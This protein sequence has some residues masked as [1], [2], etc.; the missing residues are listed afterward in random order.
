MT[1]QEVTQEQYEQLIDDAAYLQD[2]AEALSYVIDSVPYGDNPP[3]G[4]SIYSMLQLIDHAQVSYY[5]PVIEKVFSEV[6]EIKLSEFDSY[7]ETFVPDKEDELDIQKILRKIGKHRAALINVFKNIP[8]IDWERTLVGEHGQ[9]VT[10][11]SFAREMITG[12]RQLLKKIADLVLIYQNERL[13]QKEVAAK[14]RS[15]NQ[16]EN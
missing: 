9:P 11:H 2:E 13:M 16:G 5:R 1:D 8:L 6:R 12:E 3:D 10:L 4:L 15:R 7:K 14:A